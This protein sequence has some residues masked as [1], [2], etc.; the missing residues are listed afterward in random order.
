MQQARYDEAAPRLEASLKLHPQ[1]GDAWATLG[2]VYNKLERLPEAVSALHEAIKQLPDQADPHLIL[3]AVLAKQNQ[4]AEAAQERKTAANLMR[5]HMNFQ[6]A[7]VATNSGKSLLASGKIDDA[8][9][10]FRN[11]IAFDPGYAEAHAGLAE[12][13]ETQGKPA[14]ASAE[15]ERARAIENPGADAPHP[16]GGPSA[17]EGP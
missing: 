2:S 5:A 17:V 12:A 6:R 10:E 15:R 13:L 14:E 7:E 9:V 4:T 11:A 3:A 16:P 1:N 8:I